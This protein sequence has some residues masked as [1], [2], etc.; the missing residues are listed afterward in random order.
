MS[1]RMSL[2]ACYTSS[3]IVRT[4]TTVAQQQIKICR[5]LREWEPEDKQHRKEK[6][7]RE[8]KK[9]KEIKTLDIF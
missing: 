6:V 1:D 5:I 2:R 9:K 4:A 3:R 7:E 8:K